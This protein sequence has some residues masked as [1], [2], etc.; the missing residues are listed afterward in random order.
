MII[1]K[2]CLLF[3][4]KVFITFLIIFS[5]AKLGCSQQTLSSSIKHDGLDRTY[6]TYI[7]ASYSGN[8]P[9]PLLFNFHG[10]TSNA[11]EQMFYGDFRGIAD[12][13][14]F[15]IIHPQGTLDDNNQP[16]WNAHWGAASVDDI[17]FVAALID[18]ILS[19]YNIDTNRIYSAG[20][21]NGGFMGYSL[22]CDLS[23]KFAAIASVTGTMTYSHLT[24][25]NPTNP[26]PVMQI[27]GTA[28]LVVPYAGNLASG[29][30]PIDDV[31]TYWVKHNNTDT[32]PIFNEV[33]N[34]SIT[35]L[36]TAEKYEYSN[37]DQDS[38]VILY[39]IINGGHTWPGS[40]FSK[41]VTNQDID[42]SVE[43]WKFFS[44]HTRNKMI[45]SSGTSVLDNLVKT[46]PNPSSGFVK[47]DNGQLINIT[48][49]SG[50]KIRFSYI[51]S[52]TI[53]LNY[54]NKGVYFLEIINQNN[55]SEI[56][57]LIIK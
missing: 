28:D 25:C 3:V 6:I 27:H 9:V 52:N 10:Y 56:H 13:A 26:V 31:I 38:D 30:T 45:S 44:T 43:I 23:D 41:G 49:L 4:K 57:K 11:S 18:T 21:S 14:G 22:A 20:M 54:W 35:D 34:S 2:T 5:F 47:I 40:A 46:Y 7:P 39:K 8:E 1:T 29:M 53:N 19:E 24:Q 16:F 12:T 33:P 48:D 32:I 55:I 51:N 37:G 42:A 17:G 50:K 15:L 36:C